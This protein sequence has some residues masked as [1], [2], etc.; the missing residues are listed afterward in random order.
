MLTFIGS[1]VVLFSC[2]LLGMTIA[3][4]YSRRPGEIRSLINALQML[5]TEISYGS[6][7]LPEALAAVAERCDSRVAMLFSKSSEELL[8]MRG[9]TAREAWEFGLHAY[10]AKSTLQ[11]SDR[12]VLQELGNSLGV[13]DRED[14]VKHLILTKEQLKLEQAKAEDAALKNAKVYNYLG[15]LGGLTIVIILI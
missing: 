6:T 5:E 1:M 13:S 11:R 3:S 14:Q 9:V 15:F 2:T 7:P 12:A 4:N 10:Y 8:T